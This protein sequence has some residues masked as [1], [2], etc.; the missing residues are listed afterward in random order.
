MFRLGKLFEHI[1]K[2]LLQIF[3]KRYEYHG[4]ILLK[5]DNFFHIAGEFRV[6][7]KIK[8]SYLKY[9]ILPTK[10]LRKFPIDFTIYHMAN[11]IFILFSLVS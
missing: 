11:Q 3:T 5:N 10:S 9:K 8:F 2:N 4:N 1:I 7:L 6:I